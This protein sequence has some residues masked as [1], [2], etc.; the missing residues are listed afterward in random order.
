SADGGPAG[1]DVTRESAAGR[2]VSAVGGPAGTDVT[3]ESLA[4]SP[5]RAWGLSSVRA[6]EGS[7]ESGAA[8]ARG[9]PG[10][11]GSASG[12]SRDGRGRAGVNAGAGS[13][14]GLLPPTFGTR[15][16]GSAPPARGR[17]GGTGGALGR[18]SAPGGRAGR[19]A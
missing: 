18:A 5:V 12:T 1:T 15:S 6:C 19:K 3:R 7:G 14:P 9:R 16:G 2:S 10:T 4:L 11:R 17:G 8:L 13:F